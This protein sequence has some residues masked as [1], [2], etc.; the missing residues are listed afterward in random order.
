MTELASALVAIEKK[1][2]NADP[3]DAV[4]AALGTF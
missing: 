3:S 4:D 2:E 1:N